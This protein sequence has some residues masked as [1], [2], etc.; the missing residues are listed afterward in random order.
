MEP[1]EPSFS[2]PPSHAA[3]F[4]TTHW[5]HV[6][7]A[8]GTN[9]HAGRPALCRLLETYWYPLYAF[10][11]RKGR[12][13]DD[14]CDLT[15][16][17]LARL[18][19]RNLLSAA[20]PA[21]GKFRTFLLTALDRFLVDEWRREGRQKRGGGSVPLS[22]SVLDAEGR[23]RLEP[24]DTATPERLYERRWAMT[25]LDQALKHLEE[26]CTAAGRGAL[27][28]AVKPVL[29]GEDPLRPYAAIAAEFKIKE[30]ALKTQIHRLRSR[31]RTILRAEIAQ[32]LS[33]PTDVD[34]EIQHL[35]RSLT[36]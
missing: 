34:E 15:Q 3:R 25:L 4:A 33:D 10:I 17:F 21:K 1:E 29:V 6:L 18:L 23:Y 12:D 16:E 32:T 22:L 27:F 26:E 9:S 8:G 14:A 7:A 2:A 5:S 13:A 28:A 36:L 19:E 20:D 31:F 24:A 30:G 35:F 11:R